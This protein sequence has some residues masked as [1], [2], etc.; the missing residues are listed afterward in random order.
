[1]KV[2]VK[3]GTTRRGLAVSDRTLGCLLGGIVGMLLSC[4]LG[5]GVLML[6]G[7]P[8]EAATA[9]PPPSAYDI[10]AIIEEDYINRT[11]LESAA[12]IPQPLPL[13]AG[14]FDLH[15]AGRADFAVQADGG[16]VKPVFRGVVTLRVTE[17]GAI[18]VDL[19]QVRAGPI[20]LTMFVPSDLL[21]AIDQDVNRQVAERT[22][23]ADVRLVGVTSDET[24]LH[25]YL[26]SAP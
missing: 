20:P 5:I 15:P 12:S 7:A 2:H 9:L 11:F 1:M 24:K 13:I 10:E 17:S 4:C 26:I 3:R 23:V 14:H 22:S 8:P 19:V 16:P 6:S 18:D 21:D 25:F